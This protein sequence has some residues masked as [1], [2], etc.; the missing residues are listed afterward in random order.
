MVW[1]TIPNQPQLTADNNHKYGLAA[2]PAASSLHPSQSDK[3]V[4]LE[5]QPGPAIYIH[6][7]ER[8]AANRISTQREGYP[9]LGDKRGFF[10]SSS[11]EA[12]R[13]RR[14]GWAAS[15][16]EQEGFPSPPTSDP[17]RNESVGKTERNGCSGDG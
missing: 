11:P 9:K 15:R 3:H 4:L 7:Q 12:N 10:T 1:R 17:S 14:R 8:R 13:Q 6:E 2:F 16:Q 5:E